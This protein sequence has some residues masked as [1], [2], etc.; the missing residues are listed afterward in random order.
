LRCGTFSAVN[1]TTSETVY[2]ENNYYL[3]DQSNAAARAATFDAFWQG[4]GQYGF[5]TVWLVRVEVTL[6]IGTVVSVAVL[7]AVMV[8]VGAVVVAVPVGHRSRCACLRVAV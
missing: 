8:V 1:R 6:W 2:L 4:Y 3:V 5:K 7:A